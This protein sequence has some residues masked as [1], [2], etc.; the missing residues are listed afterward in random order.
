MPAD[1]PDKDNLK[2][3]A[4]RV[5]RSGEWYLFP[6]PWYHTEPAFVI[7]H[8]GDSVHQNTKRFI[9]KTPVEASSEDAS[10]YVYTSP[11][12]TINVNVDLN[13]DAALEKLDA[14]ADVLRRS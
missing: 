7:A 9:V 6:H 5:P 10:T 2:V 11:K 3:V 13:T 4:F 1:K 8:D 14:I 12:A